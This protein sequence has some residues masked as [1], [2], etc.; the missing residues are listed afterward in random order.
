MAADGLALASS[1]GSRLLGAPSRCSAI[2]ITVS[3]LNHCLLAIGLWSQVS[4]YAWLFVPIVL[5][6]GSF[7]FLW[8]ASTPAGTLLR[9]VPI[10]IYIRLGLGFVVLLYD[11]WVLGLSAPEVRA[12]IGRQLFASH[13]LAVSRQEKA[14][15]ESAAK[16]A[17]FVDSP[18]PAAIRQTD[19][20]L[21][22]L[23]DWL[24]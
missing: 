15:S 24:C 22:V 6:V 11:R 18:R 17:T 9:V 20:E 4:G 21:V 10:V 23:E 1:G 8:L 12:T 3:I 2:G 16:S 13:P 19:G 14:V 5:L 7:G